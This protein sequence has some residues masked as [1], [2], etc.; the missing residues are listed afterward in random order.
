MRL[1]SSPFTLVPIT[2][3]NSGILE[4]IISIIL[5]KPPS[6]ADSV[7][8]PPFHACSSKAGI[9]NTLA[10]ISSNMY[11]SI[12][13]AITSSGDE[14]QELNIIQAKKIS[15]LPLLLLVSPSPVSYNFFLV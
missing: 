6:T 14:D 2:Q 7:T 5:A 4:Q 11:G 10:F 12:T 8:T 1:F 15:S 3:S 9:S 13:F